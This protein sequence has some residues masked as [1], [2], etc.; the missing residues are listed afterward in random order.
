MANDKISICKIYLAIWT[1][2]PRGPAGIFNLQNSTDSTKKPS[3]CPVGQTYFLSFVGYVTICIHIL[4]T[5]VVRYF[6][7]IIV[8]VVVVIT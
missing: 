1:S 5:I 6:F 4:I 7:I 2:G 3:N 8:T